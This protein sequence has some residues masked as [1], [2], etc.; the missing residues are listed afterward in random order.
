MNQT[1]KNALSNALATVL[2]IFL[3]ASFMYYGSQVKIG[4]TNTFLIP[5]AML[6][7]FTFSAALTGFL[8][9]GRPALLYLDGKKKEA[10]SLL[11]Y[12]LSILFVITLA[13]ILLLILF[14]R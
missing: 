1:L 10:L 8:I 4:K 5:A 3:V 14:T 9:F 12:T 6:L 2:Y 11:W 7:L 13:V